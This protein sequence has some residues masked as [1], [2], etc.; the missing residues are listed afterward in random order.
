MELVRLLISYGADP[1]LAT[2]AGQAPIELAEHHPV[3][4]RLLEQHIK[5]VQGKEEKA[6]QFRGTGKWAEEQ[7]D[8]G[9]DVTASPPMESPDA[10]D[11]F[12]F[13]S[14]ELPL[15]PIYMLK[16]SLERSNRD[17][18]GLEEY[19]TKHSFSLEHTYKHSTLL[20]LDITGRHAVHHAP[21]SCQ[22]RWSSKGPDSK[23]T[24]WNRSGG[25]KRKRL[26]GRGPLPSTPWSQVPPQQ[27]F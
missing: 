15:P 13:E 23:G 19:I 9:Y 24:S 16:V 6:W 25:I 20:V 2:Y 14:T 5:D 8:N 27:H 3:V 21:G 26:P 7:Y 17:L 10:D 4:K 18:F 22:L 11:G 1:L 12:E